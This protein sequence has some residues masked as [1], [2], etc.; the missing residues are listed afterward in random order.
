MSLS[1]R[2]L[3]HPEALK[4]P[5]FGRTKEEVFRELVDV[6][7]ISDES[8]RQTVLT[9]VIKRE[10][11]FSTSLGDHIAVPHGRAGIDVSSMAALGVASSTIPFDSLD[12]K[13]VRIF[14]LLIT[15]PEES[16]IH[17]EALGAVS[18]FLGQ[19]SVRESVLACRDVQTLWGLVEEFGGS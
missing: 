3:L 11:E 13:P 15:Q 5:L 9:S 6:L 16:K 4:A 14:V 8:L 7:P 19:E 10:E 2:D 18:R 17:L 12:G 1:L